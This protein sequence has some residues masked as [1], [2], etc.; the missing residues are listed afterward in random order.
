MAQN[1]P[2][3]NSLRCGVC[4]EEAAFLRCE[5]VK[6]DVS[7]WLPGARGTECVVR[8][9]RVLYSPVAEGVGL[10]RWEFITA[11]RWFRI[12]AMGVAS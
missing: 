2:R 10:I 8:V 7:K 4:V 1:N 5:G 12:F 3:G 9:V 6:K 11:L